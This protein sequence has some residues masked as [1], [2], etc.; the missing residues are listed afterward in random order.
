MGVEL[1]PATRAGGQV[2]FD[3]LVLVV[4]HGIEREHGQEL[5]G[6]I[7]AHHASTP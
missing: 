7:V 1:G 4:F 5:A 2:R 6:F 3:P